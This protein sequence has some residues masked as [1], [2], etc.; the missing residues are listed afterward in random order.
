VPLKIVPFGSPKLP[1]PVTIN[2]EPVAENVPPPAIEP[3]VRA[4]VLKLTVPRE[5][6]GGAV[7]PLK[8]FSYEPFEVIPAL[9][10]AMVPNSFV[11]V[12]PSAQAAIGNAKA[13]NART[14]TRLI[15]IPSQF[16][17]N[18]SPRSNVP[19]GI[20]RHV[21]AVHVMLQMY[22]MLVVLVYQQLTSISR[23]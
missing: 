5:C 21:L 8:L 10:I 16:V 6:P 17:P 23:Q 18:I 15:L 1:E 4:P 12:M 2:D 3:L 22:A 19:Q 13:S 9:E 20:G 11:S 7:M 14:T